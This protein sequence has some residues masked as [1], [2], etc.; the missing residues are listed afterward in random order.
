M[1]IYQYGASAVHSLSDYFS[2]KRILGRQFN[3]LVHGGM[4]YSQGRYWNGQVANDALVTGLL[5]GTFQFKPRWSRRVVFTGDLTLHYNAFQ[6]KRFDGTDQ[7]FPA[8]QFDRIFDPNLFIVP[9]IGVQYHLGRNDW[10][11]DWR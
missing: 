8:E 4:S 11:V 2:E 3:A 5:G 7:D 10:H 6:N 1:Q 9:S